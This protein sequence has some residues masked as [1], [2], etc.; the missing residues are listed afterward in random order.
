MRR[1][2]LAATLVALVPSRVPQAEGH[3]TKQVTTK[4]EMNC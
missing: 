2:I 4:S 1:A 3:E